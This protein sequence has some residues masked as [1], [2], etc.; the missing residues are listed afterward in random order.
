MPSR[1]FAACLAGIVLIGPLAVHLFLPA[2]PAI[3]A[4]FELGEA[5]AQLTF[6]IGILAMA[7]STLAYG[8]LSDR[9][10]RRPVLLAG[11]S[12]F[13]AGCAILAT[14]TSFAMLLA[15]RVVQ[16]IGA[17]CAIT[18]VR[19]IARDAY[20]QAQ[21]ATVIAYLTMFYTLGP[22]IS[23]LLGGLLIDHYGW[24]AA[25]VFALVLGAV[26]AVGAF[27]MVHET[28]EGA[29]GRLDPLAVLRSY[30]DPFRKPVFA[31]FVLQTGFSTGVFFTLVAASSVIMKE[32]LGRPATEYGF[33]FLLF[34][35]GF[36]VGNV[37][38]TRLVRRVPGERMVLAGS[39]ILIASTSIQAAL[40]VAGY[41]SPLTLF[42]PGFLLTFAQGVALPS[43]Q[44]GAIAL[45]PSS[46]GTAA[47][48]GVFTQHVIGAAMAQLYGVLASGSMVPLAGVMM[49]S[50]VMA[51]AC[52]LIPWRLAGRG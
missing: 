26:I 31:A 38:S 46:I 43:T 5:L 24:R 4:E 42:L 15:G 13:L 22:M 48:I 6:S 32:Q 14:A 8:T 30:V 39:L 2:I 19:S 12:L 34:P 17:G 10:G 40:L 16:A 1:T 33:Y 45:V 50:A 20:G 27:L 9:Y 23:P 3:K 7:V 11:L 52:G 44:S 41:V 49:L 18:L 28:H 35:L 36:L 21:L 29:G 47:A 37:V 25:F 51:L